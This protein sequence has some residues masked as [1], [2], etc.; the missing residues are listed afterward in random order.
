M[1]TFYTV[2]SDIM[3]KTG[4]KFSPDIATLFISIPNFVSIVAS[5]S[6]IRTRLSFLSTCY[7]D[8]I[9]TAPLQRL[10]S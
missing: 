8:L 5:P 4:Y 6:A 3:Q 1:L 9:R 10:V 2:A 7:L